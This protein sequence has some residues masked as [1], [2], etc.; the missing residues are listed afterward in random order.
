MDHRTAQQKEL[1]N[2]L[3]QLEANMEQ[4]R[5]NAGELSA[6][7]PQALHPRAPSPAEIAAQ[8]DPRLMAQQQ[9]RRAATVAN[10]AAG[11]GASGM[12]AFGRGGAFS[13]PTAADRDVLRRD[14]QPQPE[15]R[16][17]PPGER[18]YRSQ[19][20]L[21]RS[22]Q[23]LRSQQPVRPSSRGAGGSRDGSF[24]TLDERMSSMEPYIDV[25]KLYERDAKVAGDVK[26]CIDPW[27]KEKVHVIKGKGCELHY[28]R[29]GQSLGPE[30][31]LGRTSTGEEV[32]GD[33]CTYLYLQLRSVPNASF[34]IHLEVYTDH[35]RLVKCTF[36]DRYFNIK[37][38]S[39]L[40]QVPAPKELRPGEALSGHWVVIA[41]DLPSFVEGLLP[42]H[43][44]RALRR[45]SNPS[46]RSQDCHVSLS[47]GRREPLPLHA[48]AS[49]R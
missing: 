8:V 35:G 43:E 31:A 14:L 39:A 36:S 45:H 12:H 1:A 25:L 41:F 2:G 26:Q 5:R 9:A 10:S 7:A 30:K 3:A 33:V 32:P 23:P 37:K 19:Q 13:A 34:T 4:M 29:P 18:L 27:L 22:Q 21:P 24:R 46:R 17:Q 38:L 16:R 40:V 47:D 49:S 15:A 6:G 48:Q 20:P 11:L 42:P 28:P 44:G